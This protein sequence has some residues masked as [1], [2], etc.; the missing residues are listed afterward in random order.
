[1]PFLLNKYFDSI[2]NA[3]PGGGDYHTTYWPQPSFISSRKY[4]FES[5]FPTYSELDFTKDDSHTLYWH[6][7]TAHNDQPGGICTSC[8]LSF[9]VKNT[10]MDIVTSL[11]P[12]RNKL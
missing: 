2:Y 4:Y 5:S 3:L 1:M 8:R 10:L 12:G 9:L 7:S 6:M 11:N